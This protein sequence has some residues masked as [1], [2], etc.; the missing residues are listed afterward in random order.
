MRSVAACH[1]MVCVLCSVLSWTECGSMSWYGMCIVQHVELAQYYVECGSMSWYGVCIVQCV[2]LANCYAEC[3]S[4]SWY[5]VCIMQHVE[6][7]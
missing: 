2:E 5:G 7:D 3:G 1:S 6:L 4:M